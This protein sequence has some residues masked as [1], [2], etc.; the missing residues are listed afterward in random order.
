MEPEGLTIGER[1][2]ACRR[3]RGMTLQELADLSGLSKG[4]LS[5]V[6]N[7]RRT[8][9]RRSHLDAVANALQVSLADLTGQ[10]YRADKAQSAAHAAI[11][12]LQVALMDSALDDPLDIPA[13]PLHLLADD[14]SLAGRLEKA[15]DYAE[16]GRILPNLISELHV[17][18]VTGE[19]SE[20]E[21]ALQLLVQSCQGAFY[22]LKDLGYNELAWIAADQAHQA[23]TRLG[24]PVWISAAEFLRCHA[25]MGAKARQRALRRA[26]RAADLLQPHLDDR[27]AAEMYGMLHLTAALASATLT[28]PDTADDHLSEAAA[29]AD[30]TGECDSELLRTGFGPTNVGI[31]RIAIAMELGDPERAIAASAHVE[32]D[33]LWRGRRAMFYCDLGRAYARIPG[34]ERLAVEKLREAE[35]L[36]PQRI[37]AYPMARDTVA[38]MLNRARAGAGG[39]DLRGLAYRMGIPH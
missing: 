33:R 8:L 10:P 27:L 14:V 28:K 39:R 7:G 38:T 36:A 1:I 17:R 22:T 21:A 25:L 12:A 4:F 19:G 15:C 2:R 24:D 5:M 16:L 32:P 23:A 34:K 6:E 26:V 29:I 18:A 37:R 20:R 11:P 30:R 13:R 31:W 9:D 35:K 3:F